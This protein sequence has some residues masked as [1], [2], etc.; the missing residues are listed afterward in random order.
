MKGTSVWLMGGFMI[1]G[2]A[3]CGGSSRAAPSSRAYESEVG[4]RIGAVPGTMP[5][6]LCADNIYA[7]QSASSIVRTP[8]DI[9][10]GPVRF[11]TLHQATGV[12]LYRFA[13]P[14]GPADGFKSPLSVS[15]TSGPWVAVW[16]TGDDD[17]VKINYD[18]ADFVSGIPGDP[19][20]GSPQVALQTAVACGN[21]VSGFVQYNGGFT[22]F[23]ATCATVQ[24]FDGAGHLLG[25]KVVPFGRVSCR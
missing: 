11:S 7:G 14:D 12:G 13:T 17:Q 16:V 19:K 25:E 4:S 20:T 15:G 3:G 18:P 23:H 2:V 22:W 1:V 24:V 9:V 6:R 21:G 5:T 8:D 10:V